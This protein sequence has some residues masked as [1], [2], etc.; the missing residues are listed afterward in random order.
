VNPYLGCAHACAYCYARFLGRWRGHKEV[1]GE[2]VDVRINA[3]DILAKEVQRR[4]VRG[5]VLL[6]SMTDAYQPLEKRYGLTRRMLALLVN[7]HFPVSILT[8]SDLVLRDLDIL[9][10]AP[11]CDVG[12][13]I[14]FLDDAVRKKIEP[15]SIPIERRFRALSILHNAGIRTYAFIGPIFPGLTDFEGILE[16][17]AGDV[18]FVMAETLNLRCG[19]WKYLE[20]ILDVL[21]P[22]LKPKLR[23]LVASKDYCDRLQREFGKACNRL[24]IDLAGFYTH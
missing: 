8:K 18:D 23:R 3:A 16:I 5:V 14:S 12:M 4:R 6:G 21:S 9:S 11:N 24:N 13:T 20:P 10:S 15:R 17:V 2:Y 7:N 1:W 19:N 22:E